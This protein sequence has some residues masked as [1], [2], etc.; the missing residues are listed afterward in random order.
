MQHFET[1]LNYDING[2]SEPNSWDSKTHPISIF[3]H[4]ESLEIDS[5]NM[6]TSLL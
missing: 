2:L 4:M 5:K 3:G 1:S 6:F